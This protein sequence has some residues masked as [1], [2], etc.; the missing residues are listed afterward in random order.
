[1]CAMGFTPARLAS[2]LVYAA[3]LAATSCSGPEPPPFKPLADVKALMNSV[4]DP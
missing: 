1:M 2:V 3:A 4:V